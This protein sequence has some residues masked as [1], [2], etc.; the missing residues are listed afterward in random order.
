MDD[1]CRALVHAA[2]LVTEIARIPERIDATFRELHEAFRITIQYETPGRR[3]GATARL[4]VRIGAVAREVGLVYD[5]FAEYAAWC[6]TQP[7]GGSAPTDAQAAIWAD[8][9]HGAVAEAEASAGPGT[10][11]L[12][13]RAV[14][15][16]MLQSRRR[17]CGDGA[18]IEA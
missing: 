1:I 2:D 7:G 3:A 17:P 6:A 13:T 4:A 16:A 10:R 5:E 12:A 18:K 14:A 9:V 8:A 11:G 15:A